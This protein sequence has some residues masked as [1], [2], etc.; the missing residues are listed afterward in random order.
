[1]KEFNQQYSEINNIPF[2]EVIFLIGFLE[3]QEMKKEREMKK[4][5]DK[6]KLKRRIR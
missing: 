2:P 4:Q 3:Q 1:M 6:L 5:K